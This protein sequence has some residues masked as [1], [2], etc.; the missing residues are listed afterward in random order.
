MF[1]EY[2]IFNVPWPESAHGYGAFGVVPNDD[3]S[4]SA[5][6]LIVYVDQGRTDDALALIGEAGSAVCQRAL[7]ILG[8]PA[9][10]GRPPDGTCVASE[11]L[12]NDPASVADKIRQ[13]CGQGAQSAGMVTPGKLVLAGAVFIGLVWLFKSR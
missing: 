5:N 3:L 13:L 1:S 8:L 7:D 12:S 6:M 2:G 9:C 4:A 10:A 11:A